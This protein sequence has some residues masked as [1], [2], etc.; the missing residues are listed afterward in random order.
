MASTDSIR[1]SSTDSQSESDDQLSE[2][3]VESEDSA[4]Q[5]GSHSSES[6]WSEPEPDHDHDNAYDSDQ[7]NLTPT[8]KSQQ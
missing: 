5:D 8:S 1:N 2:I 3:S 4:F 6:E 7:A